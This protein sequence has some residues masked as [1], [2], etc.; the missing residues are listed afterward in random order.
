MK[1]KPI[2]KVDIVLG[3][4]WGDEGKGK[5]VDVLAPNY[6][7]IARFQGGPNAGHT[8]VIDGTKYVL[9]QIP[10]GLFHPHTTCVIG[11]GV[12]INP[13]IFQKELKTLEAAGIDYKD[14]L[15]LSDRAHFI[16]PT[17]SLLDKHYEASKAKAKELGSGSG[18][19]G[20]T[21]RGIS[22]A[23]TDKVLR[24]GLR[25]GD[26]FSDNFEEMFNNLIES[27]LALLGDSVDKNELEKLCSEFM[28][29]ANEL[30]NYK[31]SKLKFTLT[32]H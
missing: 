32:R 24:N 26:V 31:S 18:K 23:Y 1:K 30:K 5:I 3:L 11:N 22:P 27:H 25:L 13:V 12:I 21:L 20:S 16:L 14:R 17:H 10:S 8:L 19:I 7:I 4:Q 9:H 6:D 2:G 15:L 28:D 29:A